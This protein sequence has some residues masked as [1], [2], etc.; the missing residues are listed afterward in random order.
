MMGGRNSEFAQLTMTYSVTILLLK[1]NIE[2]EFQYS[3]P[4]LGYSLQEHVNGDPGTF[5][6]LGLDIAF[7]WVTCLS[8]TL[9]SLEP[10]T[11][12]QDTD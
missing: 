4:R 1:F 5:S 6:S 3:K 7:P 12:L 8:Q 9:E 11:L 10:E 2:T